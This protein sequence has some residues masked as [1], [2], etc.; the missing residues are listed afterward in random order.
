MYIQSI[1]RSFTST[2]RIVFH[3]NTSTSIAAHACKE[4]S[5]GGR[6]MKEEE[7]EEWPRRGRKH[8]CRPEVATVAREVQAPTS[9]QGLTEARWG[10]RRARRLDYLCT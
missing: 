10:Q 4:P 7:K 1:C 6:K 3:D 8:E 2:S 9:I 5:P